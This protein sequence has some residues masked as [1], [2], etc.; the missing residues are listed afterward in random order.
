VTPSPDIQYQI[1]MTKTEGDCDGAL[2]SVTTTVTGQLSYT[3]TGLTQDTTYYFVVRAQNAY[4]LNDGNSNEVSGITVQTVFPPPTFTK[5]PTVTGATYTSL[6]MSWAATVTPASTITYAVCYSTSST[7]CADSTGMAVTLTPNTAT[8]VTISGLV[9]SK[10]ATTYWV[11]VTATSAGGSTISQSAVA[12]LADTAAPATPTG[13][14]ATL[15]TTY[16]N[17]MG[18]A[19]SASSD[20]ASSAGYIS[21]VLCAAPGTTAGCSITFTVGGQGTSITSS[22]LGAQAST[23]GA[24]L[25]SNTQYTFTVA[26]K[27]QAGN[28]SAPS[29][30]VTATTAVSFSNDIYNGIFSTSGT[31]SNP[32]NGCHGYPGGDVG[33]TPGPYT[34]TFITQNVTPTPTPPD[35]DIYGMYTECPAGMHFVVAGNLASSLLYQKMS[36][37]GVCSTGDPQMPLG[38]PYTAA[39][40][41]GAWI[42]QGANNN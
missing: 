18:L 5:A 17:S 21:Y 10:T 7:A 19:W 9:P 22:F 32:C 11:S 4:G 27:D 28:Q 42:T 37:S 30:A 26:A 16:P 13:L 36:R 39:P 29:A 8:S 35:A 23:Q 40:I 33:P 3:A 12:T 20:P 31:F 41:V 6:P 34:Y 2:F 1:C 15:N 14:V 24:S 25:G 38:G